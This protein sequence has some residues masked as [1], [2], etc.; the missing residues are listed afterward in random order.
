VTAAI[1][2]VPTAQPREAQ[3][4]RPPD[5]M[6]LG[7][8][9]AL[10]RVRD[11]RQQTIRR[12]GAPPAGVQANR[13]QLIWFHHGEAI[14]LVPHAKP[15]Q[16]E[17]VALSLP[18]LRVVH[19]LRLPRSVA[20]RQLAIDPLR[21]EVLVVGNRNADHDV[22]AATIDLKR[23]KVSRVRLIRSSARGAFR[24]NSVATSGDGRFVV[25]SYHGTNTTGAD[26]FSRPS[27]KRC[28]SSVWN[29]G[30]LRSVHGDAVVV[31]AAIYGTT[32]TPPAVAVFRGRR[33]TERI[34]LR[35]TAHVTSL[36]V[37]TNGR[38]AWVPGG[39][40]APRGV[41]LVNLE[42][43]H[44]SR[45]F[46]GLP[47]AEVPVAP[48]GYTIN[49]SEDGRWAVTTETALPVPDR[50]RSGGIWVFTTTHQNGVLLNVQMVVDPIA[51][52]FVPQR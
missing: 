11:G 8:N 43:R 23:G 45:F 16:D 9:N 31:R 47:T 44:A 34:S 41:W 28:A 24:V 1:T 13:G 17:L 27:W 49:L 12:F 6:V 4:A 35:P 39:C 42:Q 29:A 50:D 26:V 19:D 46:S 52:A 25:V 5:I 14:V 51:A 2:V 15:L 40:D 48:C 10:V 21:D 30:C 38:F 3:A 33:E 20:F 22:V 36:D 7:S 18:T 37:T 32:G